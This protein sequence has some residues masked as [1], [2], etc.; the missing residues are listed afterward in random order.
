MTAASP[1]SPVVLLV[2]DEPLVRAMSQDLLEDAG[3]EVVTAED[4]DQALGVLHERRD[5]DVMMTDINM[6]G[7]HD[8]LALARV[9]R[10]RW[11]CVG[12]LLVSGRMLP[13]DAALPQD[14]V[15]VMKPFDSNT[16]VHRIR[17]L[18]RRA[19]A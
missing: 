11:P 12:T 9:V 17:N 19:G 4:A 13:A 10:H 5:I 14:S 8:G 16:I 1:P 18:S 2:E 7:R 15:F 6:P 3:F